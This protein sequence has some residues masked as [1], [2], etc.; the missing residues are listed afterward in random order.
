MENLKITG[1]KGSEKMA[2]M[3]M[4][5]LANKAENLGIYT[6]QSERK[7]LYYFWEDDEIAITMGAIKNTLR[8]PVTYLDDVIAELQAIS[9]DIKDLKRVGL[10]GR[11]K[12]SISELAGCSKGE[13]I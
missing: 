11:R 8:L 10:S 9:E 5:R 4:T 12:H 2:K 13:N 1:E 6:I 7:S 3:E